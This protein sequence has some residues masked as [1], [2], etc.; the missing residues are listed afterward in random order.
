MSFHLFD[1]ENTG[2]E[3][4]KLQM[5]KHDGHKG[6]KGLRRKTRSMRVSK[7]FRNLCEL[8]DLNFFALEKAQYDCANRHETDI[9]EQQEPAYKW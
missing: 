6:P 5:L 8:G 3:A 7:K 1:I 4:G 9:W 2:S